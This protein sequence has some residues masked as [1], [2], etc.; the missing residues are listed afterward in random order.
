MYHHGPHDVMIFLNSPIS[1]CVC[2]IY[3]S[4]QKFV[5]QVLC[6]IYYSCDF[7]NTLIEM[8]EMENK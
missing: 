8:Y 5:T 2:L 7:N 6:V 1:Q 4:I 3:D